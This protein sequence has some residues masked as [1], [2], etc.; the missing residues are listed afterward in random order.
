MLIYTNKCPWKDLDEFPPEKDEII[1]K[2][3]G[4]FADY[5]NENVGLEEDVYLISTMGLTPKERAQLF[6]NYCINHVYGLYGRKDGVPFVVVVR[7]D[8]SVRDLIETL[9]HEMAHYLAENCRAIWGQCYD[10]HKFTLFKMWK[11]KLQK[12][13]LEYIVSRYVA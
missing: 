12:E 13:A 7:P 6:G 10:M 11:K 2:V 1:R 8:V 5:I 9:C 4:W 3:L